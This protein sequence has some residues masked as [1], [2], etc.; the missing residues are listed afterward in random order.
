MPRIRV[1]DLVKKRHP[2]LTDAWLTHTSRWRRIS[3]GD[4]G[5]VTSEVAPS[6]D[7]DIKAGVEALRLRFF[8]VWFDGKSET[9][10]ELD[11]EPA[12]E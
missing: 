6:D 9:I 1:G 2:S 8:D 3:T 11:L 12:E 5:V 4:V 10:C 7:A